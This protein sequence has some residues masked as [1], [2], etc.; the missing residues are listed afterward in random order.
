MTSPTRSPIDLADPDHYADGIPHA[1]LA[2]LRRTSP[3]VWV[4]E[5][6]TGTFPGGP[7]FWAVLRH[8][9]V[10]HVSRTP[11]DFSSWRGT[12]MLRD[13]RP[14]DVRVLRRMMLNMDPPEHSKLRKIVNRAFTPQAIRRQLFDSITRHA[15]AVVDAVCEEGKIDF[16]TAVAAEMPLRVLADVL[17]VRTEDRHLLFQWTNTLVGLDDP[18][19]GGDPKAFVAAFGEMFAYGR[20][21]TAEKRANPTGDVWSTIVN[22]EVDGDRL[23]DDDLDRFF[24]LLVIAG[25]DTTRNLLSNT[26]LTLSQHP[27]QFVRLRDD[28]GL[29]PS[30]LEE[31]LRFAPSVIQFRRTATR[32]LEL[33]GQHIAENDKVEINYASANRDETVFADPD[34]FDIT[35]DPNPHLSFGDGTHFCLG[36]NLARLQARTLLTELLTRLPDIQASGPPARLRSSFMNGINH[37]PAEFTPV[38]PLQRV[39]LAPG[40]TA[41]AP[42]K[43]AQTV[44]RP[45]AERPDH[46]TPLLVLYGSNFGTAEEVAGQLAAEGTRR[47]FRTRLAALDDHVDALPRDGAVAIATATYNGTPPDNAVEFTR[48]LT[49]NE[50]DLTGVSYAVFGCGNREWTDTFQQL[51]AFID[52]RMAALGAR[53]L[54]DRGVGDAAGDF[55]GQFEDWGAQLWPAVG[56]ALGVD[57]GEPVGATTQP[58][59]RVEFVP[60]NRQSPFVAAFDARPMPVLI[61]RELTS[62][63][64]GVTGHPVRHIELAL[65]D[66]VHYEAGDHLGVIPHNSDALVERVTRRFGLDPDAHVR[67]H[68]AAGGQK[69]F[70]PVG[71]RITIRRLLSDYFELQEVASRRDI[72]TLLEHTEYPWTRDDLAALLNPADDGRAYREEVLARRRSVLDLLEEHPTCQVPFAVFL[73][74]LGPLAPRYYSI[75]SSPRVDPRRC[76]I[77]VGALTGRARSGRGDFEGVCSNYLC[78]QGSQ[79]IVYGFVRDTASAFR[80]PADPARPVIM[81]GAGTGIAPYRGFLAERAAH[82]AAGTALGSSLLLFGCRHPQSDLLYGDELTELAAAAQTQLACAFSRVPGLPRVY[83]QD[84]LRQLGDT[85]WPLLNDN[86]VVYV[87]G[88]THVAEGV[89][90]ALRD[91]HRERTGSG[92][93][94]AARW[95]AALNADGRYLVDVWASS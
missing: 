50:P 76:S 25:N 9:E 12:S 21:R 32:D 37:L 66:D 44:S 65:P 41:P 77:T 40:F 51:P 36:A 94:A 49:G 6:A 75:S 47:G 59:Y 30:A 55:D 45:S 7:G 19:H 31:V 93:V 58:R 63:L 34:R 5:P 89:R 28:L 92:E 81:I 68:A 84:R 38:P 54:H 52:E 67:L 57:V 82:A 80:L 27:D 88:S 64:D 46:G 95:L 22:A 10:A 35:R 4:D 24:Q 78:R 23:S 71:E 53:R 69:P 13:P 87:C 42:G 79:Q 33:A 62:P 1:L 43:A 14:S 74:L 48:W 72:Q 29:L 56:A 3:I 90:D 83:V 18:E 17:G 61:S 60:G 70:L 73:Q 15:R 26:L 16:V 39:V 20:E 11:A 2:Q 86:A 91:L 85:V 8:A